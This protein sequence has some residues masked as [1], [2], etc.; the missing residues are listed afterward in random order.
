MTEALDRTRILNVAIAEQ[1]MTP[2]LPSNSP[3]KVLLLG[4]VLATSVSVGMAFTLEYTYP[5]S[6]RPQNFFR[7]STFPC[8]LWF[9]QRLWF[10]LPM[11]TD[12][13]MEMVITEM[14]TKFTSPRL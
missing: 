10:F 11:A 14:A 8:W 1:P 13:R 6:G 3:W 9:R 12:I 2:A 7:N 5:F 4:M